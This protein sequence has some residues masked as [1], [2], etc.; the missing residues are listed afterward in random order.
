MYEIPQLTTSHEVRI[1]ADIS[2]NE[3]LIK[4]T[5]YDNII[6]DIIDNVIGDSSRQRRNAIRHGTVS[7]VDIFKSCE[8]VSRSDRT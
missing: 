7:L 1:V 8:S 2:A 5:I 6:D 3:D 4:K